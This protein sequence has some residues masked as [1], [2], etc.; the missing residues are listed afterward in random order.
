MKFDNEHGGDIYSYFESRGKAPL[1]FS[2]NVNPLGIPKSVKKILRTSL[3]LF[4]QYPDVH[5]RELKKSISIFE[6]V[7]ESRILAGNGAADLVFRICNTLKPGKAMIIAPTFSEYESAL[8]SSGCDIEYYHLVADD[9]FKIKSDIIE[10]IGN[11]DILFLCNP[12]NPTGNLVDKELLLQILLKCQ[13]VNCV[14]VVDECFMDFVSGSKN[15]TMKKYLD[16]FDCLVILKAFTKIF[17]LAGLRLGYCLS[18]N[19]KLLGMIS[20]A[21]QPWCVSVPAQIAGAKAVKEKEYI[22]KTLRNTEKERKY[23]MDGLRDLKI[24]VFE[25]KANYILIRAQHLPELF[26]KLYER[27][28]LIRK[29]ENFKGLDANYFRIAVKRHKDNITLIN[30]IKKITEENSNA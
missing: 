27:G 5:C 22:Q 19:K 20:N 21:G 13:S 25:S 16:K 30:E 29:C 1:D 26:E 3:S 4:S 11:K 15:H 2:S 24:E 10:L 17:A 6:N 12:N 8:L 18:S 7:N 14:L 23:L 28:I 9:G